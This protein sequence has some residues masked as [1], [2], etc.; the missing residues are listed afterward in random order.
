MKTLDE[1]FCEHGT[2]KGSKHP[3]GIGHDYAPAYQRVFEPIRFDPLSMLEIGIGGGESVK[4]WLEYFAS[5]KVFG[6]DITANT[7]EWNTPESSP[8]PRYRFQQ[9]DQS[10]PTMWKCAFANW[11][12]TSLD[13]IIDDGSHNNTDII[14]AFGAAWQTINPGGLYCIEDLGAGYT[15]GSVHVKPGAPSH[16]VWLHALVDRIVTGADEIESV[17]FSRELAIIRKRA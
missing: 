6:I 12:I 4:S 16:A 10:D 5:G 14:A 15:P 13:V 9:G 17:S 2:D 7:N 11:G 1:I 8:T 3:Y